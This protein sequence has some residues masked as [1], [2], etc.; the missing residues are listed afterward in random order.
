MTLEQFNTAKMLMERY[1][2]IE[3]QMT[4]LLEGRYP[5]SKKNKKIADAW[6]TRYDS[7]LK[8]LKKKFDEL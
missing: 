2:F 1:D 4:R 6:L 7:E 5:L 3:S 8:E